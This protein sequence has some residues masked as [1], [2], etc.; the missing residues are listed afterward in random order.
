MSAGR[1][2]LTAAARADLN[3]IFDFIQEDSPDAASRVLAKLR[4]AMRDLARMP[5]MGHWRE[6]LSDEPLRFWQVYSYLIIYRPETRPLQILRVL[7][8]SRD[9]RSLLAEDR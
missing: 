1:F 6:D 2:V 3:D 9:V 4:A 8:A 7:H 5:E